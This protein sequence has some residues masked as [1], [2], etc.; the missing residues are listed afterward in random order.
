MNKKKTSK[1]PEFSLKNI[2]S[3]KLKEG[4]TFQKHN[5]LTNMVNKQFVAQALWEC[6]V[7]NDTQGF[8]EILKTHLELINKERFSEKSGLSRRTLF[9][10]LSPEGNPTLE[11]LGKIIHE[12]CA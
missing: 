2:P 11:N 12:L 9:R 6:L 3:T 5:A 4:I 8:K 10:I 7:Q 1:K